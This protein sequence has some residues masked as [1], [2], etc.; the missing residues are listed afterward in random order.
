MAFQAASIK[1]AVS[2]SG[3]VKD[4]YKYADSKEAAKAAGF[5]TPEAMAFFAVPYKQAKASYEKRMAAFRDK[6]RGA[7]ITR[8]NVQRRAFFEDQPR[9]AMQTTTG[10]V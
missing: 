7:E 3:G 6:M 2:S 5:N 10:A 9:T 8:K 4:P 1:A